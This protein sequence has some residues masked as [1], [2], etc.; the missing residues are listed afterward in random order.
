MRRTTILL[1]L[2]LTA[3]GAGGSATD[4]ACGARGS[5][6]FLNDT[7]ECEC[8]PG[9]AWDNASQYDCVSAAAL[10][11]EPICGINECGDD[12]CGGTCGKCPQFMECA[13]GSCVRASAPPEWTCDPWYYN[14]FNGCHCGCGCRY[15]SS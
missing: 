1:T 11:C 14:G 6:S 10:S 13:I 3:C 5:N 15:G 8:R 12:G 4:D 2:L 9:Y 7:G